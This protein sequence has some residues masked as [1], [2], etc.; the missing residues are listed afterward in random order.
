MDVLFTDRCLYLKIDEAR[1][2]QIT[3]CDCRKEKYVKNVGENKNKCTS[4]A[5]P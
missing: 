4:H 3:C 1:Q 5:I 2:N